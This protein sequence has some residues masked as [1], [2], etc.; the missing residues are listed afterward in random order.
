[1][2][3]GQRVRTAAGCMQMQQHPEPIPLYETVACLEADVFLLPRIS[4]SFDWHL[5]QVS[6]YCWLSQFRTMVKM[7]SLQN[8]RPV[9]LP[10]A[11]AT[12]VGYLLVRWTRYSQGS[13][14]LLLKI[15][16]AMNFLSRMKL[17]QT[18]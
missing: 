5:L 3:L 13:E 17:S 4:A 15:A 14:W 9:C 11:E 18:V 16:S 6:S 8:F 2:L 7:I 1:M 10:I 12:T